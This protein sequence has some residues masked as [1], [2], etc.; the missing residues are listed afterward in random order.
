MSSWSSDNASVEE[1]VYI[2][3]AS[4]FQE[5]LWFHDQL[6]PN[7]A[8]YNISSCFRLRGLLDVSVLEQVLHALVQRHEILRTTFVVLEGQL[9]QVISPTSFIPLQTRDMRELPQA[10]QEAE[11]QRLAT[12]EAQRPF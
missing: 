5:N 4:F 11:A 12:A 9:V 2:L 3:P 6:E 10:E 1:E 7:R 8:V